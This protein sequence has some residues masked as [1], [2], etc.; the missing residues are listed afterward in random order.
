M[1]HA[2]IAVDALAGAFLAR[3][4]GWDDIGEPV[5][6]MWFRRWPKNGTVTAKRPRNAD[7]EPW[8][9]VNADHQLWSKVPI[10]MRH[11][12]CVWV[13][14]VDAPSF[15]ARLMSCPVWCLS[16]WG[17]VAVA[18]ARRMFG[19]RAIEI[20]AAAYLAGWA[21]AGTARLRG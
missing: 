10:S 19:R 17:V 7:S 14:F 16:V 15:P 9:P 11:H 21:N 13:A 8:V 12:S 1:R 2:D 6:D 3:V 20:L 4:I 18:V 5:R